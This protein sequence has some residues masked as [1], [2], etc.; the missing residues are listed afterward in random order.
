MCPAHVHIRP[1]FCPE[2]RSTADP[3][4][5]H[6]VGC[7]GN[8]DRIS[9]HNAICDVLFRAAQSAALSTT[10]NH[11]RPAALD[12]HVISSLQQQ[13]VGEAAFTSGH[14]LQV[15]VQRKLASHLSA[16]RSAGVN[17]IPIVTEVLGGL[18]EDTISMRIWGGHWSESRPPKLHHLHQA[19]LS[20][21]GR[22]P[23]AGEC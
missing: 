3:F 9:R 2:C 18:A 8:G 16:C 7:G 1:R 5:D 4:G 23:V 6:Q 10:W 11:G 21:C 14:A 13:T 12:I 19:A 17:F 20:S 22:L 15:G